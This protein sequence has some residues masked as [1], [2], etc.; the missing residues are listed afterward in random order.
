MRYFPLTATPNLAGSPCARRFDRYS[1]NVAFSSQQWVRREHLP[2]YVRVDQA[3]LRLSGDAGVY[4][5][6]FPR[7]R[8]EVALSSQP[9]MIDVSDLIAVGRHTYAVSSVSGT[10]FEATLELDLLRPAVDTSQGVYRLSADDIRYSQKLQLEDYRNA[11]RVGRFGTWVTALPESYGLA[12]ATSTQSLAGPWKVKVLPSVSMEDPTR[13]WYDDADWDEF[14]VPFNSEEQIEHGDGFIWF[15][16]EIDVPADWS[17]RVYL[18]FAGVDDETYVYVD[19]HEVGYHC[20][21]HRPFQLDI[22]PYVTPGR[23]AT[24]VIRCA[25]R[26]PL[27]FYFDGGMTYTFVRDYAINRYPVKTKKLGGIFASAE[28]AKLDHAG[29]VRFFPRFHPQPEGSLALTLALKIGSASEPLVFNAQTV[30]QYGPPSMHYFGLVSGRISADVQ[31]LASYSEKSALFRVDVPAKPG[32]VGDTARLVVRVE[33]TAV[34]VPDERVGHDVSVD[35]YELDPVGGAETTQTFVF[36]VGPDGEPHAAGSPELLD[37]EAAV[38]EERVYQRSAPV[39]ATPTE[40]AHLRTM[41]QVLSL[42]SKLESGEIPGLFTDLV[43]YPIFWLRDMAISIPGTLHGGDI[44][45]TG[46]VAAAG[47]VY[48]RAKENANYTI[49]YPDGTMRPAQRATDAPPL[50]VYSIYKVWCVA[51][52]EWL[53][54]YY[55]TVVSYMDYLDQVEREFGND[56]DGFIRSSDGDWWDYKYHPRFEREG[57]AFFVNVLY[58]R[59]LKY[60]AVMA[61]AQGD[62]ARATE[63]RRRFESGVAIL[64]RPIADGGLYLADRGYFADTVMTQY[65]RHPNG[66][67][68]PNDMEK[69]TVM[70]GFR[71]IPHA[72]AIS[73]GFITDPEVVQKVVSLMD[74]YNVIRPFPGLVQFPWYD[75]MGNEGVRGPHEAGRFRMAW[76]AMPGNHTAGGRWAFAGG[77]IEKGLWDAG[78]TELGAETA[79]NAAGATTLSRQPARVIEDAHYSGLFRNESGDAKDAEG[80]Y[81]NWGSA[82]PV[83]ALVE[84]RYGLTTVPGGVRADLERIPVGDGIRSVRVAGGYLSVEH[85]ATGEYVVCATDG[86]VELFVPAAEAAD[87]VGAVGSEV[88][89]FP[90]QGL[91]QPHLHLTIPGDGEAVRVRL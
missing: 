67:N 56:P 21:W 74:E 62:Q 7:G 41:K 18:R 49:L 28:L 37:T 24:V 55:P 1:C 60:A 78:A 65:D 81:Y 87:V 64:N 44:A 53:A 88:D 25:V 5:V 4:Q 9:V 29:P 11:Q 27:S 13:T 23:R 76:K 8:Q 12:A 82:T 30:F 40:A 91:E 90:R 85:T 70:G 45:H 2:D 39:K 38:W 66:Y 19:G 57:A 48:S 22:S 59:A 6:E 89:T 69:V 51:G 35:E 54:Q 20:G 75:F 68:Y 33:R 43:K 16:R 3:T 77:M 46:A 79:A 52:D 17:D 61:A 42:V 83:E 73:E 10:S 15:R 86:P 14:E 31:T 32:E 50:A 34:D 58:L 71:P 84:G 72:I 80:F 26:K 47:E 63:W 36:T